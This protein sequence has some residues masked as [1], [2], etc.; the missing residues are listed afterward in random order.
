VSIL[1]IKKIIIMKFLLLAMLLTSF[2]T[3][4]AYENGLEIGG[5]LVI[6]NRSNATYEPMFESRFVVMQQSDEQVIY[7]F[8][9]DEQGRTGAFL[10]PPGEYFLEQQA[11]QQ[12]Y[13]LHPR[14]SFTMVG[15]LWLEKTISN[16][17]IIPTPTPIPTPEPEPTGRLIIT[18]RAQGTN[19]F[20][21]G[22]VFELR[23]AMDNAFISELAT[24][25]FGEAAINLPPGD[26]FLREIISPHGFV[27]NPERRTVRIT[28][29]RIT[30]INVINAPIQE[31]EQTPSP[32]PTPP[33]EVG[34]LLITKRDSETNRTLEGAVFEVRRS[35]D[36]VLMGHLATNNFGEAV[37]NLMPDDYYLREIIPP[38]GYVINTDRRNFTI[39][40]GQIFS[41][42][43][44]NSTVQIPQDVEPGRLL[45]TVLS[46]STGQR[47]SG[48][49]VSLH[50]V[51]TDMQI[52][53]MTSARFGEA[54]EFLPPGNY[55]IRQ[56]ELPNGYAINF[57]RIPVTI[58]PGEM[59]DIMIVARPLPTPTPSPT[60]TPTPPPSS[61]PSSPQTPA[62]PPGNAIEVPEM[63]GRLEIIT[64]AEGSGNP[65]S[66]GLFS[67]YT[68][69]E[70]RR[71]AELTTETGGT[72]HIEL[73]PG[74]YLIRELRPTYGFLLEAPH[75]LVDV[76]EGRVT[77]IEITKQRDT[78]ILDIDADYDSG[79]IYIPQTGQNMSLLHYGGGVV[80]LLISLFS[81]VFL[82]KNKQSKGRIYNVAK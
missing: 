26:Y 32:T 27:L 60:P 55:F 43:I 17:P 31:P 62:V 37:I 56:R 80:M 79:K 25:N 69:A 57:D 11:V 59:T 47:I 82:I 15:G 46:G 6:F 81:A 18:K 40:E 68:A 52:S 72:A 13:E 50:N 78:A 58:R 66:G 16:D 4:F 35:R 14:I 44:Q 12:G 61:L 45:V 54:S 53:E 10:L 65:L 33:T 20:L 73:E 34:R 77:Q 39:T 2:T 75:I 8:V 23:R 21:Q 36:D 42:V 22:A 48:A 9:T 76:A 3:I 71:I 38:H 67:I 1:K 70:N 5:W 30:E 63:S 24:N 64:R 28:A 74:Q 51:M 49:V 29:E 7:E 19:E 41:M